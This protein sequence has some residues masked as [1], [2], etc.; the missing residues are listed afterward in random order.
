[1]TRNTV[2]RRGALVG[3]LAI[4]CSLPLV[5][6]LA[7]GEKKKGIDPNSPGEDISTH[8][9]MLQDHPNLRKVLTTD[10]AKRLL[11]TLPRVTLMPNV[12]KEAKVKPEA[13]P[14][15]SYFIAEGD[16]RFDEAQLLFWAHEFALHEQGY[17]KRLE[18][19]K[20]GLKTGLHTGPQPVSKLTVATTAT[21]QALYWTPGSTVNYCVQ[22]WTFNGDNE[23]Q[24]MVDRMQKATEDW[25]DACNINFKHVDNLDES[26]PGQT[27][28]QGVTFTVRRAAQDQVTPNGGRTMAL[29]FFP[30]DG[31]EVRHLWV[32]PAYFGDSGF[33]P[34]GILR[35]ELGHIIGFRHE[36]SRVDTPPNACNLKELSPGIPL[37]PF[38]S[39]SVMQ[40]YCPQSGLGSK[41]ME[42]TDLDRRGA[43]LVYGRPKQQ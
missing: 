26:A 15:P 17:L 1:M 2:W 25:Q 40:Y 9:K 42:I 37:G 14:G 13:K 23:Y 28:P 3:V 18:L 7:G 20:A 38:D 41:E 12:R 8:A 16:L 6:G 36:F 32:F 35:H 19:E 24:A 30:G 22:K 31:G 4:A 43:Q 11:Q 27:P 21:G 5:R 34:T 39:Q 33:N 29:S 10:V